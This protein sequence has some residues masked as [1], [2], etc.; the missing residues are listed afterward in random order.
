[1]ELCHFVL[2][3]AFAWASS[4]LKSDSKLCS[5]KGFS[6]RRPLSGSCRWRVLHRK[7][8][9]GGAA[10]IS[11]VFHRVEPTRRRQHHTVDQG[12]PNAGSCLIGALCFP[13]ESQ[14][15]AVDM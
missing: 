7:S 5:W 14:E 4:N 12:A 6:S 10:R 15:D 9:V 3:Q 13:L 8:H 2:F 11:Y 1:M